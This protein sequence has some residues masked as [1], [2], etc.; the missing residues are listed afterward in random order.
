M[1][2]KTF[3]LACLFSLLFTVPA[4]AASSKAKLLTDTSSSANTVPFINAGPAEDSTAATALGVQVNG[5]E[6]MRVTA[7]GSVGIGTTSPQATLDVNGTMRHGA[8]AMGGTWV[9]LICFHPGGDTG[10]IVKAATADSG[11]AE[12]FYNS[13]SS[14][15]GFIYTTT[16]GTTYSTTSDR[17]L[18]EGVIASQRGLET[19]MKIPVNEF[20]FISDPNKKRVQGFIA[21]ELY[22]TYPE[23]VIVGG[24]DVRT[25]P[26]GVDYGR[27]TPLLV[28]A[29]QELKSLLDSDHD[30]I[31]KLRTQNDSQAAEIKELHT[32]LEKLEARG[33]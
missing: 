26:W 33:K 31:A 15:I 20:N 30:S 13:S 8:C 28:K 16:N 11:Y 14:T 22:K 12:A 18:K 24:D 19:L 9:D 17:R 23:A 3:L 27:L 21:Q 6:R 25:K 7:T 2:K 10:I 32:R 29:V 4:M 1:V 5:T